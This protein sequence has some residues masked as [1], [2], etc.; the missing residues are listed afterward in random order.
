MEGD[1]Y[2]SLKNR[3]D[4]DENAIADIK[5]TL[6]TKNVEGSD[7]PVDAFSSTNTV[8]NAINAVTVSAGLIIDEVR[9]AR[10]DS[11][12]NNTYDSLSLHLRNID[13][14][15]DIM[16]SNIAN[17]NAAAG[18]N[19]TIAGRFAQ[20]DALREEVAAAHRAV[21]TGA[22]P[23]TLAKR[24]SAIDTAING[25]LTDVNTVKNTYVPRELVRD[26]FTSEDTDLPLSA[27]KGKELR[28]MIG[29]AYNSEN[30][31][32]SAINTAERNAKNH[33]DTNKVD[34][35]NIYNALDYVPAQDATDDKVLDARQGKALK[36]TIDALNTS[37][38]A[39]LDAIEL[40]LNNARIEL[41]TD[42][43]SGDPLMST[44]D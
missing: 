32:A 12:K 9:S 17:I 19:T 44:L 5:A 30:T 13:S 18:E 36:D 29:G 27:N 1:T 25:I 2:T 43:E 10:T 21:E 15:I 4:T 3:F 24:F 8:Y 23:D 40:E 6:G 26:N 37:L 11:I 34:K 42:E 39:R 38:D 14:N 41:G 31:V 35:A 7:K 22:E 16:Q 20:L 28:D 33:A